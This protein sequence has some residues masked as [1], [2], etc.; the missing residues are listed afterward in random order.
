VRIG[1]F[2]AR[3][4][5]RGLGRLTQDFFTH[6]APDRTLVVDMAA[7]ARG[8]AQHLDRYPGATVVRFN[9]GRFNDRMLEHFF[10]GL[11]VAVMYETAYDH[12]AYAVAR[13][14][15]CA[16]VLMAMPEFHRHLTERLPAP[17]AVWVPTGWLLDRFPAGTPVVPVPVERE[18]AEGGERGIGEPL[19]VLHVAGHRATGDRNGTLV[20]LA[21]L[22]HLRGPVSVRVISQDQHPVRLPRTAPGVTV[23]VVLGGM[24]DHHRLYDGAD[25]LVM[26]R[27]YGGL[28]LPVQEALA[29]GLGVV[30]TDCAPNREWPIAPVRSRPGTM[31]HTPGGPIRLHDADPVDL[32]RVIDRLAA[33]ARE[34]AELRAG[35]RGWARDHTW[36]RLRPVYRE[37]L[38][39][40]AESRGTPAR[41][42]GRG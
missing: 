28:C 3:A 41:S 19:R 20:L 38:A 31:I 24:G 14:V 21:A 33:D 12:R 30:M 17:D 32:A 11:D 35:A 5:E 10:T 42:S 37:Q 23:E 25:V 36:D 22:A 2:G 40:V 18:A 1:L 13:S 6:M 15:G 26:P 27:R 34:V 4:D 8:F 16:T 29:A 7:H 9:G 39:R